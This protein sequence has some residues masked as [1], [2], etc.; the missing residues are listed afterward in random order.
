MTC[1]WERTADRI[2]C[3][4]GGR[5]VFTDTADHWDNAIRRL[6]NFDEARGRQWVESVLAAAPRPFPECGTEGKNCRPRT[7][8]QAFYGLGQTSGAWAAEGCRGARYFWRES[9]T[10][11][12]AR[13][14]RR[15]ARGSHRPGLLRTRHPRRARHPGGRRSRRC[16]RSNTSRAK[17]TASATPAVSRNPT[18]GPWENRAATCAASRPSRN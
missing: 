18:G 14:R 4:A 3:R 15:S 16:M 13:R 8:T 12:G 2:V 17:R 6:L 5:V 10:V 7:G 11:V 1:A 9:R